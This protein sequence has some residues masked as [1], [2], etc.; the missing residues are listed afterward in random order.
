[1]TGLTSWTGLRKQQRDQREFSPIL[2]NPVNRVYF[3][4]NC[5]QQITAELLLLI[6]PGARRG[7]P[8]FGSQP[9]YVG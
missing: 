9:R 3:F 2:V 4:L 5:Q 8:C 6:Q 1:M 7:K